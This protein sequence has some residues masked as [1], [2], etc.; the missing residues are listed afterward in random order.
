MLVFLAAPNDYGRTGSQCE[1]ERWCMSKSAAGPW[2]IL[3]VSQVGMED[4]GVGDF[5]GDGRADVFRRLG[6]RWWVSWSG[7]RA[8][9]DLR[10]ES[11]DITGL[12][13]ADFDGDGAD[14][15]FRSGCF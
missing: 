3:A 13:L 4:L 14:D 9:S 15:V 8:W 5:D 11:R 2:S 12:A 1:T 7:T 10:V 6:T